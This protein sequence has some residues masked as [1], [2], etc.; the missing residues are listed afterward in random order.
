MSQGKEWMTAPRV[1]IEYLNGVE[2]FI[3]FI[4]A[5]KHKLGGVDWFCRPCVKCHN[6]KGGKKTMAD[7]YTHLICDGIYTTYT[8]WI[9]HGEIGSQN[10]AITRTS[11]YNE[12][13]LPKMADM[14]NDVFGRVHDE[15]DVEAYAGGSASPCM[16]ETNDQ[17]YAQS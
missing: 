13:A 15:D 4:R 16:N 2:S 1:S 5:N 8:S 17:E 6:L 10:R 12:D 7:I 9:H 11:N 14:V 3:E